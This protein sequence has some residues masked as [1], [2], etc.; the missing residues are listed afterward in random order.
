MSPS[1]PNAAALVLAVLEAGESPKD[2][3][4]KILPGLDTGK[5][6][7]IGEYE[8][9]DIGID[10]AQYFTGRGTA[11]TNWD[12]VFVGVGDNPAESIDDALD[13]AAM[14][15]WNVEQI[16]PNWPTEPSASEGI[17][18]D[19][20][21]ELY[22]Y[23]AVWIKDA[24]PGPAAE[25]LLEVESPKAFMKRLS[26]GAPAPN[27]WPTDVDQ[28]RWSKVGGFNHDKETYRRAWVTRKH[29]WGDQQRDYR[30]ILRNTY[31]HKNAGLEA[32]HSHHLRLHQTDILKWD[33]YG[34]TY[35]DVGRWWTTLTRDR[36]NTFLPHG[37]RIMTFRNTW[38][39]TNQSWPQNIMDRLYADMR[40]R[41]KANFPY[42]LE[43]SSNGDK[44]LPNGTLVFNNGRGE[45]TPQGYLKLGTP[46]WPS[47][48]APPVG[49][50]SPH[51]RGRRGFD[52]NQ[53][54]LRLEGRYMDRLA[55]IR[56]VRAKHEKM[57]EVAKRQREL[58]DIDKPDKRK[59]HLNLH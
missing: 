21:S 39:W 58:D 16:Q 46:F 52:P 44:I 34:T 35:L 32:P 1:S 38:Y 30:Y 53:G 47:M 27:T 41:R 17:G 51:R 13:Q 56:R 28:G 3:F 5:G 36:V 57:K 22:Y 14:D 54:Q 10:H 4:R 15:G 11:Y 33:R 18:P 19:E 45:A 29:G 37:W 40:S 7:R 9:E 48:Q 24:A 8:L 31:F 43:V 49:Q 59:K 55:W 6:K 50:L 20:D 2:F 42:W 25:S 26:Q 23:S 12:Y